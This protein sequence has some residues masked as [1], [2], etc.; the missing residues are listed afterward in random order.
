MGGRISRYLRRV[1]TTVVNISSSPDTRADLTYST[2]RAPR[3]PL[4][5]R[6]IWARET[7]RYSTASGL[8]AVSWDRLTTATAFSIF[9]TAI[10]THACNSDQMRAETVR[11]PHSIERGNP[12]RQ[13]VPRKAV[14]RCSAC[15]TRTA[16]RSSISET[17]RERG[18]FALYDVGK[19]ARLFRILRSERPAISP[20]ET[21][22][23][24][25]HRPASFQAFFAAFMSGVDFG[26]SSTTRD[27]VWRSP[28]CR[29]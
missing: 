27:R 15:S 12:W 29:V 8:Y 28:S 24:A 5:A 25:R 23:C 10:K 9:S 14:M 7:S 21:G 3:S 22:R 4:W 2:D 16:D 18:M 20:H 19:N 17:A 26:L 11:S 1:G 13:S 6:T